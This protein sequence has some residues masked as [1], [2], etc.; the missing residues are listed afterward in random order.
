MISNKTQIYTRILCESAKRADSNPEGFCGSGFLIKDR[1]VVTCHHVVVDELKTANPQ[2][3]IVFPHLAGS[4]FFIDKFVITY[5]DADR[6]IVIFELALP[7]SHIFN[8]YEIA[9][10]NCKDLSEALCEVYYSASNNVYGL[11]KGVISD[12]IHQGLVQANQ[13]DNGFPISFGHSGAP[14][15]FKHDGKEYILGMVRRAD[16]ESVFNFIPG[17]DLICAL[18]EYTGGVINKYNLPALP[19]DYIRNKNDYGKI[20]AILANFISGMSKVFLVIGPTGSGKTTLAIDLAENLPNKKAWFSCGTSK[21]LEEYQR[22]IMQLNPGDLLILD[23]LT[24]DHPMLKECWLTERN[25]IANRMF[26]ILITTQN[27]NLAEALK[28]QCDFSKRKKYVIKLGGF[29][30]DEANEF[31]QDFDHALLPQVVKDKLCR[32]AHGYPMLLKI[33]KILLKDEAQ[34]KLLDKIDDLYIDDP[35]SDAGYAVTYD[36]ILKKAVERLYNSKTVNLGLA[37]K[38]IITVLSCF[39]VVGAMEAIILKQIIDGDFEPAAKNLR[40]IGFITFIKNPF[41]QLDGN[42]FKLVLVHDVFRIAIPPI[43]QCDTAKY[44]ERFFNC[45]GNNP[46]GQKAIGVVSRMESVI[47]KMKNLW[48]EHGT[49]EKT[50]V[51]IDTLTKCCEELAELIP[52]DCDFTF[53]SNFIA[54]RFSTVVAKE[55]Y[56][57]IPI[58]VTIARLP[59]NDMLA[60]MIWQGTKNI[61]Y[62]EYDNPLARACCIFCAFTHWKNSQ[63]INRNAILDRSKLHLQQTLMMNNRPDEFEV[64]V[65]LSGIMIMGDLKYVKN[66]IRSGDFK[67]TKWYSSILYLVLIMNAFEQVKNKDNGQGKVELNG[68]ISDLLGDQMRNTLESHAKEDVIEFLRGKDYYIPNSTRCIHKVEKHDGLSRMVARTAFC[69]EFDE[70]ARRK[71]GLYTII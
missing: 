69:D 28:F 2:I 24:L 29:S 15:W 7:L 60:E 52:K 1:F 31:F 34:S 47:I 43:T 21:S 40:N 23:S 4:L 44:T 26:D 53:L 48:L 9:N 68:F 54:E 14:V 64:A 33:Y 13:A 67:M 22:T 17:R 71:R 42:I 27:E 62:E 30:L 20:H 61:Y 3:R 19:S 12:I 58:A 59:K 65:L 45:L 32:T 36:A 16:G 18:P 41:S 49:R 39:S 5:M 6:D 63:G 38:E 8:P 51:F 35:I 10:E 56:I 11:T 37:E 25:G 50:G 55:C 66:L 46:K 57:V 70:H